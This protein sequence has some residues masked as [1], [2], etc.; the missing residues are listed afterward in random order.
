MV[1]NNRLRELREDHDLTQKKLADELYMQ[2]TQYRRY[3]SGERAI[4]LEIACILADYYHVSL[5]Y[6][7]G[8][9]NI[10]SEIEPDA[11]KDEERMLLTG[12]RRLNNTNRI[13]LNERLA[14]LLDT[15]QY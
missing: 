8:R 3:E 13:R 6:L 4:P 11:L 12:F 10:D 1:Y 2:V 9:R 15:Q 14:A 5:D 7:S